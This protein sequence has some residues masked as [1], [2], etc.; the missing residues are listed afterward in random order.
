[1]NK[2]PGVRDEADDGH[3]QEHRG[4]TPPQDDR[5]PHHRD[6]GDGPRQVLDR[7]RQGKVKRSNL[8]MLLQ[9]ASYCV[10]LV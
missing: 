7:S 1:M 9:F 10:V 8:K 5:A 2:D 4:E 3:V 6:G